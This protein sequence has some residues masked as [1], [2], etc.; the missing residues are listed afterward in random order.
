[1]PDLSLFL[2]QA[3]IL[4]FPILLAITCHELAHG[5]VAER[6]GDPTAR[7][8]GRLTMNPLAHLDP[9][10]TLVFLVT[11]MIGWAKPV[12]VNPLY[13]R[14]PQR[15]MLWVGLA[16]PLANLALAVVFALAYRVLAGLFAGGSEGSMRLMI[17]L[18]LMARAGVAVNLGLAIFNLL[19]VPPLDGSR[20]LAGILPASAARALYGFERYGFLIL[21]VLLY[22]RA[23]DLTIRPLL[24]AATGLLLGS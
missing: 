8:A 1:M 10:G 6:L 12:P 4:A 19:P 14:Q 15:A 16:G 24:G 20:V 7:E 3:S 22:S 11:G 18:L 17:P 5:R 21:L 9:L 13:F 23:F 2:R